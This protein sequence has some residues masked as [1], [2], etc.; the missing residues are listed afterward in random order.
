MSL[1]IPPNYK[2]NIA[3]EL[4][5]KLHDGNRP[6]VDASGVVIF[7]GAVRASWPNLSKPGKAL[8][9]GQ[10]P[11]FQISGLFLHKNISPIMDAILAAV[12]L[13]YPTLPDPRVFLDPG[14]K[15]SPVKDQGLKVNV[16][17][18]G[19]EQIKASTAG[20]IPG[21]PFVSGK[22][23]PDRPPTCMRMLGGRPTLIP[24]D[25]ADKVIYPGCWVDIKFRIFKSTSAQNPGVFLGL[26]GVMKLAD[27][28]AF[29]GGGGGA[30]AE[31]FA[32]ATAIEDPNVNEIAH[33]A[34]GASSDWGSYGAT[35]PATKEPVDWD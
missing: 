24:Q 23:D 12:R 9:P 22:S 1:V 21:L 11:K 29:G 33:Q 16:A 18:G 14:N 30:S 5:Q 7:T 19:R 34:A 8:N 13:H 6:R 20:Y 15:N 31:D 25:E 26:Q 4:L 35:E 3:P 32:G 2:T 10:K 17:D 27:D 28:T